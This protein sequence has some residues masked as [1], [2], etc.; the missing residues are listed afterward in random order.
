MRRSVFALFIALGASVVMVA[1]TPPPIGNPKPLWTVNTGLAS[2]DSTYYHQPSNSVFV[3]N[4]SGSP[5]NKDGNG[6]ITRIAP[7]GTLLAEKWATGL[8][9]PK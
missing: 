3:S 2:P 4:Y 7:D 1:Q 6:Y 5:Y 8:N 9:A